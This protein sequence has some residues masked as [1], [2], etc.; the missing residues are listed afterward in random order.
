MGVAIQI[1][2]YLL[3]HTYLFGLVP[4]FDLGT[5]SSIPTWYA[6]FTLLICTILL[7]IIALAKKDAR[8][9]F[10]RHWQGLAFVFLYLSIDEVARIHEVIGDTLGR[11]TGETHGLL[12]FTWV[13]YGMAFVLLLIPPY[14]KFLRHLPHQTTKLFVSAGIVYLGGALGMEMVN[15]RHAD[16]YG[17][18][19]LAY[20]LMTAFEEFLE[21]TGIAIFIYALM[22]YIAEQ[23]PQNISIRIE[24][25]SRR[26]RD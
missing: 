21:M 13:I 16:L 7:G 11:F 14:I 1:S 17:F 12:Y 20:Q 10:T 15:A 9:P 24:K 22:C 23:H 25:D 19:N 8:D 4:L 18:K 6:S 2:K 5:D 3:G 26:E